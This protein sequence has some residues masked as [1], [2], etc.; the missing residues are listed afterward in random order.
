MRKNFLK[1]NKAAKRCLKETSGYVK[2]S[3]NDELLTTI[4]E[5]EMIL[6]FRPL[7]YISDDDLEEPFT[8]TYST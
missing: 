2:L 4:M 7:S 5:V 1:D 3:Y 6:N 8:P